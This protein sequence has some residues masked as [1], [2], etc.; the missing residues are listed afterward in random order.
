MEMK[1]LSIHNELYSTIQEYCDINS[2][3]DIDKFLHQCLKQGFDIKKYGLL[4]GSEPEKQIEN[5]EKEVIKYIDREIIKEISVIQDKDC[6]EYVEKETLDL[7]DKMAKL[8]NT[9]QTLRSELQAKEDELSVIK[10]KSISQ[11]ATFLR[12]TNLKDKL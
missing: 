9:L 5:I 11:S 8:T 3:S 10:T 2:I 1:N 7:R 4:G 6:S 12:T